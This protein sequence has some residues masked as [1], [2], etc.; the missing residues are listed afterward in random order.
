MTN[1]RSTIPL[2]IILSLF[3]FLINYYYGFKGVNPVDNFTNYNSGFNFLLDKY[4]FKDFWTATGPFLGLIQSL[5]FKL[6][7]IN[8]T[9]YVVHAS[10]F[11]SI[12]AISLFLFLIKF[13]INRY[14]SLTYSILFSVIFYPPAGTPFVDHHSMVFTYL[15]FFLIIYAL[16]Y[17]K[18]Y[19]FLF[20][21][22]IFLFGFF[23][24]QTPIGYFFLLA[25][26]IIIYNFKKINI[27]Y[28]VSFGSLISLVLFFI[29][30]YFTK[31]SLI[32]IYYQYFLTTSE[33]GSYRL[34][35]TSFSFY[36]V[37]FRYRFIYASLLLLLYLAIKSKNFN[38]YFKIT[39]F[40]FVYL[41]LSINFIM[42][43]HQLLSMN[44]AFIYSLI[45]LNS[46]LCFK[47]IEY[48]KKK[49]FNNK[50]FFLLIIISVLIC[51]RYHYKYNEPRRFNDLAYANKEQGINAGEYFPSLNNLDWFT[52][53]TND[54]KTEIENLKEMYQILKMENKRY[55]L[56]TDYQ[57]LSVELGRYGNFPIKWYHA[58]VSFPNMESIDNK[59]AQLA[60]SN[61]FIK[62]LKNN[63]IDKIYFV[64]PIRN[65]INLINRIIK[66]NCIIYETKIIKLYGEMSIKCL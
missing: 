33:V 6:F 56:I 52:N 3:S 10:F 26:P 12:I 65:R 51:L 53:H 28:Y 11:N 40:E 64:P 43:F 57:F 27:F 63:N 61:F 18:N 62:Q 19:L 44:Q 20:L 30:I 34:K 23:S 42:I 35:N 24:K 1:I 50:L 41:L 39:K 31:T 25:S 4:P 45:F 47:F 37:F 7:G 14:L 55:S 2:I 46:G 48:D 66:K 32:D 16:S 58:D 38:K 15:S 17:G 21:P 22:I 49:F 54:P 9:A 29:Y 8:W 60:F 5:F 13:R 36:D 59:V